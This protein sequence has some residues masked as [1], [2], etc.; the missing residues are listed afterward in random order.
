[1]CGM[2]ARAH[3]FTIGCPRMDCD[4]DSD[5]PVCH[6]NGRIITEVCP[7]CSGDRKIETA[8]PSW[9]DPYGT[10]VDRCP[11]C[12]DEPYHPDFEREE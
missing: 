11:T 2:T 4:G 6:G 7:T 12:T 10:K 5:C 3:H 9:N 8:S 1:M